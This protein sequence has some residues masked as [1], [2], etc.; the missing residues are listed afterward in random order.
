MM[1]VN[2]APVT[3]LGPVFDPDAR[4]LAR[5]IP[6]RVWWPLLPLLAVAAPAS[7]ATWLVRAAARH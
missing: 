7:G 5:V 3:S 1:H 4:G 2:L 6:R